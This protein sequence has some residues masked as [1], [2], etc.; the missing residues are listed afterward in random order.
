MTPTENISKLLDQHLFEMKGND[1]VS[2]WRYAITAGTANAPIATTQA[3]GI[4]ALADALS[5]SASQIYNLNKAHM[6][7]DAVISRIGRRIVYDVD[8]ARAA[9]NN[10]MAS[11][12]NNKPAEMAG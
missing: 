5:C 8:K 12:K 1:I 2:L 4:N 11:R 6:L 9:A 3:I 7:D 10:W